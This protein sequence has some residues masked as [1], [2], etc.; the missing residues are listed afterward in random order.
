MDAKGRGAAQTRRADRHAAA[1]GGALSP[2]EGFVAEWRDWRCGERAVQFLS[3]HH[4]GN[5]KSAGWESAARAGLGD[6][7]GAGAA[8]GL[9]SESRDLSFSVVLGLQ[10]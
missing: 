6:V 7:A 8:A 3:Q 1:V 10:R 9:Q 4:A 5:W 2:G